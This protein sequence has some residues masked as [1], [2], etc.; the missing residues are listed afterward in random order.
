MH[1]RSVIR[2]YVVDLLDGV[3]V[4]AGRVFSAKKDSVSSGNVPYIVVQ[5]RRDRVI[6]NFGEEP[7]TYQRQLDLRVNIVTDGDEEAAN[8]LADTVENLLLK[9]F[10]LGGHARKC[11]LVE[12]E[13]D[14]DEEGSQI[15]WDASILVNVEY[16]SQFL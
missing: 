7:P 8:T 2:Q 15:Y 16:I 11:E 9:D 12:T 4:P 13:L 10:T 5:A 3:A 14:P 6:E 1:K